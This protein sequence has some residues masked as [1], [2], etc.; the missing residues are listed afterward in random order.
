MVPTLAEVFNWYEPWV[1]PP[2]DL[3]DL[4]VEGDVAY[5]YDRWR[6]GSVLVHRYLRS[7][8]HEDLAG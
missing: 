2:I 7:N 5:C 1:P 4:P 8:N 3:S 6:Q